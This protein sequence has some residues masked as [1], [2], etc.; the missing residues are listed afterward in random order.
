MLTLSRFNCTIV[1]LNR[2]LTTIFGGIEDRY[3]LDKMRGFLKMR[4]KFQEDREK[5]LLK[6]V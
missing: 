6:K 1:E 3:R 5:K 2:K 4:E